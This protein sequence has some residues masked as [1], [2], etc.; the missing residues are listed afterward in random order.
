[1]FNQ[2][3][4]IKSKRNHSENRQESSISKTTVEEFLNKFRNY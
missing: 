3:S 4:T 1:M 2:L